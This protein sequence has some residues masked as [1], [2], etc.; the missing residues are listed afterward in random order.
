MTNEGN[1]TRDHQIKSNAPHVSETTR[2][3]K[4]GLSRSPRARSIRYIKTN[5]LAK[6]LEPLP[7]GAEFDNGASLRSRADTANRR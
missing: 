2:S 6:D 1:Q 4:I 3:K 7:I 5:T